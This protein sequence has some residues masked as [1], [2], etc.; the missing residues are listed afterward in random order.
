MRAFEQAA[1]RA[2]AAGMKVMIENEP[3]FW[4]DAPAASAALLDEIG[5]PALGLNWDPANLHWGGTR[6]TPDHLEAVAPHLLNLHVKDYYPDR[7]E[8]PWL[9]V[10]EGATPWSEL[11]PAVVEMTDLGLVTLETHCEPLAES[12]RRSLAAVQRMLAEAGAH[13]HP[14]PIAE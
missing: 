2:H 8:A 12:T 3:D 5:H 14:A 6:P 10:G 7:P 9:P 11:L 1:E 13:P 4:I